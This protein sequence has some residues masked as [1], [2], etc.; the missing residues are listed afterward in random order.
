M[1]IRF[2]LLVCAPFAAAPC[3]AGDFDPAN[4][5]QLRLEQPADFRQAGAR[6]DRDEEIPAQFAAKPFAQMI[7]IAARK[8][9]LDPALVHA[10]IHV[11][12]GYN[13]NARSAKGALGLMQVMPKTAARY[14]IENPTRSIEANLSAGTRYL[15]DLMDMFEGRL[16]LVLAA[17]NAGENS[18]VRYGNRIPPYRETEQYVP[19]EI[20][21][22]HV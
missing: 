16:E 1:P 17:Y 20:G 4:S 7:Q 8:A 11:E 22:A 14:G 12:S 19:A 6:A 15:R 10:V 18:V 21:R 9:T 2:I 5:Y 13:P 3:A